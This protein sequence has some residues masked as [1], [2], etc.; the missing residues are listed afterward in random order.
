MMYY[1]GTDLKVAN[2]VKGHLHI[3]L[4]E[5]LFQLAS[6]IQFPKKRI[7]EHLMQN[8]KTR[9]RREVGDTSRQVCDS[10]LDSL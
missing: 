1:L 6:S 2:M 9:R 5:M 8:I 4:I 3:F 10:L 7:A